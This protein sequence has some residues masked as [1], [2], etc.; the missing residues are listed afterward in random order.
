MTELLPY[1][2]ELLPFDH[3]MKYLSVHIITISSRV[4]KISKVY[5]KTI[6]LDLIQF[7]NLE[8]IFFRMQNLMSIFA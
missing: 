6:F 5:H 4:A 8:S 1:T 3:E 7:F 2:T